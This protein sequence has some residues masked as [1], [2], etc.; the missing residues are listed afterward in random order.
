MLTKR[1]VLT[2]NG[3]AIG[4]MIETLQEMV[5]I[6]QGVKA[7]VGEKDYLEQSVMLIQAHSLDLL[8]P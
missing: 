3:Q 5:V 8:E 2:V 7:E 4:T 6:L 1:K